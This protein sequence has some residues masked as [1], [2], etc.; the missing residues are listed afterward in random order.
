[1]GLSVMY[2][3]VTWVGVSKEETG[4]WSHGVIKRGRKGHTER[5]SREIG[6]RVRCYRFT[7][8]KA[9]K[10]L[11]YILVCCVWRY[12]HFTLPILYLISC[13]DIYFKDVQTIKY[14]SLE[15]LFHV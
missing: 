15:L 8:R 3:V 11:V 13:A 1:M 5:S 4:G 14:S 12:R 2:M 6:P 7:A 10:V 9:R